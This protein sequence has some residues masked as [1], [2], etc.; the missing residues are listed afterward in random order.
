MR[1]HF[2]GSSDAN[3][4]GPEFILESPKY[5]LHHRPYLVSFSLGGTE[6]R[7]P[8]DQ[9]RKLGFALA[10]S[11]RIDDRL[12]VAVRAGLVNRRG[13]VGRIHDFVEVGDAFRTHLHALRAN[14]TETLFVP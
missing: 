2:L 5:P 10:A 13:V 7:L 14:I 12:V 6:L 1:H 4:V 11:V 3:P 9:Q 8:F